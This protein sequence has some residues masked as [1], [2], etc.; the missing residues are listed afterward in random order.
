MNLLRVEAD[1]IAAAQKGESNAFEA[2]FRHYRP[3]VFQLSRRFYLPGADRDD[4]LQEGMIGFYK[5]IRDYRAD[6]GSFKTFMELC[7]RRQVVT[8]LKSATRQKHY[9]LN[10]AV[11]LDAPTFI[12]SDEPIESR[13][14]AVQETPSSEPSNAT[15]ILKVLWPRCSDLERAVVA[16]CSKGYTFK[17]MAWELGVSKK[18]IDNAIWRVKVKAK[19]LLIASSLSPAS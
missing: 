10:G 11:S 15:I 13:L 1:C 18:S 6:R 16:Y 12:D 7:V 4:L 14:A 17:E 9:V 3:R 5:A 2:L 19:K 8:S